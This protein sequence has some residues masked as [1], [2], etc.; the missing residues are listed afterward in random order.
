[1]TLAEACL[2]ESD[3]GAAAPLY[4]D[5]ATRFSEH[6][7]DLRIARDQAAT[8]L[9]YLGLAERIGDLFPP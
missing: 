9:R 3:L 7:G 5:A 6:A 2:L 1:V 4:R 8:H